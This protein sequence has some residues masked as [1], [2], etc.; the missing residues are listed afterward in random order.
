MEGRGAPKPPNDLAAQ[1][2]PIRN[3]ARVE[4][5]HVKAPAAA[6]SCSRALDRSRTR[7]TEWFCGYLV[8]IL[9]HDI[10]WSIR[11]HHLGWDAVRL[12]DCG[13]VTHPPNVLCGCIP[14]PA[15]RDLL[16]VRLRRPRETP[17]FPQVLPKPFVRLIVG[18][19]FLEGELAAIVQIGQRLKQSLPA[20]RVTVEVPDHESYERH[21]A[22]RSNN[23][24]AASLTPFRALGKQSIRYG[25]R[26]IDSCWMWPIRHPFRGIRRTPFRGDGL[27]RIAT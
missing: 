1:R 6:V 27:R 3:V 25:G 15:H 11:S 18:T 19:L 23:K 8:P 26:G 5:R 4:L 14:E 2:P 12:E 16:R 17:R 22:L 21:P 20:T 10:P 13:E 7:I 24:S 9:I